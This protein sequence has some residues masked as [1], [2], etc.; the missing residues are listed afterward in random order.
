MARKH[1][2]RPET[3]RSLQAGPTRMSY[4]AATGFGMQLSANWR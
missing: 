1:W 3:P 4:R 2:R